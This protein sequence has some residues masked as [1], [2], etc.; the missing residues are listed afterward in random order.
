[1]N[2]NTRIK[3]RQLKHLISIMPRWVRLLLL[4]VLIFT[5]AV[6]PD[7]FHIQQTGCSNTQSYV[8][9]DT[10]EFS[11]YIEINDNLPSFT[12]SELSTIGYI[13]LSDLDYLGRCGKAYACIGPETLP[14]EKRGDISM[15]KPSG[16]Q[17]V[18][19]PDI[20]KDRS[21]YN[22]CHLLGFQLTGLNKEKR[23]LITG[24]RFL[25]VDGMLPFENQ[26]AD[27]VRDTGNHVM[28]RVSPVFKDEELVAR[29][30][31]MEGLSVEDSGKGVCF[32]VY[33]FNEQPGIVIDYQTGKS[34]RASE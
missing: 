11:P 10:D 12:E 34:C 32:H 8:V 3:E 2:G 28:Y 7:I 18:Q 33:C 27:Y 19:Y 16:W 23:N 24:T 31:E 1:M 5:A 9:A 4:S 14:T 25:N 30:V 17:S 26:I 29:G 20:I 6:R 13:K 22:R 21:L 15:V